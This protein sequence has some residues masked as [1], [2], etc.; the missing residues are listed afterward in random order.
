[1]ATSFFHPPTTVVGSTMGIY[2]NSIQSEIPEGLSP[3]IVEDGSLFL[4]NREEPAQMGKGSGISR[5][6]FSHV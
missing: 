4:T 6:L 3:E 2:P 5:T 1:M